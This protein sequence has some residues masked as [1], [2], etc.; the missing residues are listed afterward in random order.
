M[1]ISD[2]SSDVCSSDLLL[3]PGALVALRPVRPEA[4]LRAAQ[5]PWQLSLR[6]RSRPS[7]ADGPLGDRSRAQLRRHAGPRSGRSLVRPE[8]DRKSVGKGK[9]GAVRVDIGGRSINKQTK[10]KHKHTNIK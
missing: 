6:R 2:W 10:K 5:P 9:S 1:R 4:D 3:D 7:R 8:K